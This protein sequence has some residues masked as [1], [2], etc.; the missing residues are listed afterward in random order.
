MAILG[1]VGAFNGPIIGALCFTFLQDA[2][3][4]VTPYWRSIMGATLILIVL[5]LPTGLS[6]LLS[7]IFAKLTGVRK[8]T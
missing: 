3:M 4:S 2:L 8:R 6:G 1:G 5:F 7:M